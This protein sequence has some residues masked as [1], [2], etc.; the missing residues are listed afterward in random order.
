M[1][2]RRRA[3]GSADAASREPE[4]PDAVKEKRSRPTPDER[5]RGAAPLKA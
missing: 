1:L 2:K 3:A 5:K 4:E